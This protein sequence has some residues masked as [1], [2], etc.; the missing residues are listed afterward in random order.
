MKLSLKILIHCIF[1]F[2]FIGAT[3]GSSYSQYAIEYNFDHWPHL[4]INTIWALAIFYPFYF[5]LI[6]YFERGKFVAYLL[7]GLGMS[8]LITLV[9]LPTHMILNNDFNPFKIH[10]FGPPLVGTFILAQCGSL[11]RGFENWFDNIKLKAELENRNLKNELELLKSQVNPHFLFNTLNNIDTLIHKSP[12]DAS[13][14]LLTLSD[15]LRYMIY[16]SNTTLVPL[17]KELDHLNHYISLQQLRIK[18][19]QFTSIQLPAKC[20][21]LMVAPL[22]FLPF[23]E[24]AY[25]YVEK[26]GESPAISINMTCSDKTIHFRCKN[27]YNINSSKDVHTGGVG[28]ENVRKRLELIYPDKHTLTISNENRI[29]IVKLTLNVS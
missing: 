13:R 28:L 1:W 11:V 2:V 7:F 21:H 12:D 29:F 17:S 16:D 15:M 26:K 5:Y 4:L 10:N 9:F 25:K 6:R 18:D 3:I 23:V 14:S 22:L 8:M 19:A 27:Q 20:T 24:N